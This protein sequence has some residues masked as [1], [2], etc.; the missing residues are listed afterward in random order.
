MCIENDKEI[1][2]IKRAEEFLSEYTVS[3]KLLEM[4]DYEKKYF[5]KAEKT[6][7]FEGRALNLP[8]SEPELRMKMFAIRRFVLSLGNCNEK[9]FLFYHY[10]HGESTGRVAELMK[11]SRRSA[12]RLKR[13][14]L[15]YAAAR[16]PIYLKEANKGVK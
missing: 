15:E 6:F 1:T 14:A 3:R 2:Y 4:N 13:R 16:Y 9:L 7:D 11:I 8:G 10:I 12:F 5:G